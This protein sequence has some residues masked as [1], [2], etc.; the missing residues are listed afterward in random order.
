M[1]MPPTS[2]ENRSWWVSTNLMSWKRVIDQYG[3][4]ALAAQ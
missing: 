3:P 4:V 2:E 1:L